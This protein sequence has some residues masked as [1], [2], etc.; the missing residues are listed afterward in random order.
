[1]LTGLELP[2]CCLGQVVRRQQQPSQ[3]GALARD[4]DI[5]AG[6]WDSPDIM[7]S[8]PGQSFLRLKTPIAIQRVGR[9]AQKFF[10]QVLATDAAVHR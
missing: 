3:S 6:R 1:M 5:S 9:R 2:P 10:R 8:F 4:T 7:Q